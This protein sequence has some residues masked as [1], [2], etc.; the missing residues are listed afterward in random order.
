MREDIK[1]IIDKKT[2]AVRQAQLEAESQEQVLLKKAQDRCYALVDRISDLV[3]TA[4]YVLNGGFK[5]PDKPVMSQYGYNFS[6][7]AEGFYHGIGFWKLHGTDQISR[8]GYI[9]GGAC[10]HWNM[11][12]STTR[13]VIEDSLGVAQSVSPYV[14]YQ[15]HDELGTI[16]L[17]NRHQL[18]KFAE[19]FPKLESAFYQWIKD[20]MK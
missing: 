7:V 8:I 15:I 20:G 6:S 18:E 11:F 2:Q 19:E 4:N 14:F 10:G 12:V 17:A 13:G 16:M 3:E 9:N 5:L 1:G